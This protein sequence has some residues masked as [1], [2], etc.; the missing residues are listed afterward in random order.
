MF[1]YVKNKYNKFLD[2]LH[3][4]YAYISIYKYVINLADVQG[5]A[6]TNIYNN[7]IN[8]G[9]PVF[10]N[11]MAKVKVQLLGMFLGHFKPKFLYLKILSKGALCP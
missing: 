4:A 5:I 11:S 3:Y 6:N 8:T 9:C 10:N 1:N 7:I 2:L